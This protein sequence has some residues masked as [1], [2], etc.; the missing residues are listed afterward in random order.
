LTAVPDGEWFCPECE[1]G[2]SAPVEAVSSKKGKKAKAH[3]AEEEEE[4]KPEPKTA[5]KRKAPTKAKAGGE[6]Y[7]VFTML[8]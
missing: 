4:D 3:A 1:K 8:A 6:L 5:G 7:I 2:S